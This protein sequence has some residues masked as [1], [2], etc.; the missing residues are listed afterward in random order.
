LLL[1]EPWEGLDLTASGALNEALRAVIAAGTQLVCASHLTA[2]RDR[3]THELVLE[4]GRTVRMGALET[5]R[6][7]C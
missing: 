7:A 2:Y 4:H 5:S 6:Y 1:D 3:F